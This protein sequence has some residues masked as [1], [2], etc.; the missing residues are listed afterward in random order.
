M[1]AGWL[2]AVLTLILA[3]L[4]CLCRKTVNL[5]WPF[6]ILHLGYANVATSYRLAS[7]AVFSIISKVCKAFWVIMCECKL[8]HTCLISQ[9]TCPSHFVVALSGRY[10]TGSLLPSVL[11]WSSYGLCCSVPA[12]EVQFCSMCMFTLGAA[13][14][15]KPQKQLPW[16]LAAL[17]TPAVRHSERIQ[18]N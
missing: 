1:A 14:A 18:C 13:Q 3:W 5:T 12:A 2:C 15:E 4:V 16:D 6:K 7:S 17:T 8:F 11:I 9:K 10:A